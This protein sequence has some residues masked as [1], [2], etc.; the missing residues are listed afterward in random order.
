MTSGPRT[1]TQSPRQDHL[2]IVFALY[3]ALIFACC[4]P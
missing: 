1:E 4:P 2:D 3:D